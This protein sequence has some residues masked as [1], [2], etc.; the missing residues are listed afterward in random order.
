MRKF[1][2]PVLLIIIIIT[3]FT[4]VNTTITRSA[5]TFQIKNLGINTGGTFGG[6]QANAHFNP[7]NL[8]ASTIEASVDVNTINTD[9]ST[10]DD[11]L[12]S[13]EFFDVTKYPKITLKSVSFKHKSGDKYSGQFNLTI[14]GK[15]RLVEIPFTYTEKDNTSA[16]KSTFKINRLDFGLGGDSLTMSNEVTVDIDAEGK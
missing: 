13:D 10:R 11:H 6:L 15:T 8:T 5:I 2:V 16:F 1:F 4:A 9:N 7:A 3:A 12:K 14:K